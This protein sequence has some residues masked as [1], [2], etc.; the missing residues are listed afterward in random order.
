[1]TFRLERMKT[2]STRSISS[3]IVHS[4][5]GCDSS[6]LPESKLQSFQ[7]N[8]AENSKRKNRKLLEAIESAQR[9][10]RGESTVEG[11]G[12]AVTS[13]EKARVNRRHEGLT[14]GNTAADEA[15]DDFG[16]YDDYS[17]D[18]DVSTS[19]KI[20]NS[21]ARHA[22]RGAQ[23]G[24]RAKITRADSSDHDESVGNTRV[25]KIGSSVLPRAMKG[26]RI[27]LIEN[28]LESITEHILE[29][30][31]SGQKESNGKPT[32]H[33]NQSRSSPMK[34]YELD[35]ETL[36]RVKQSLTSV[37][38]DI[39]LLKECQMMN[40]YNSSIGK[41]LVKIRHLLEGVEISEEFQEEAEEI[42][43]TIDSLVHEAIK[44]CSKLLMSS[45]SYLLD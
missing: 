12:P 29:E 7:E 20:K 8:L 9:I 33:R 28:E 43:A 21:D 3:G 5:Q 22:K 44:T 4:R 23:L 13:E 1:M 17:H 6:K 18:Q 32:H 31:E 25:S 27:M 42:L 14:R 19:I 36:N 26:K 30:I 24:K 37:V 11:E 41:K 39:A 45:V 2:R 35:E 15:A 10:I 40:V 34:P 38:S 16:D